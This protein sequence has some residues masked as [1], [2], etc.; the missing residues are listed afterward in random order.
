VSDHY[1]ILHEWMYRNWIATDIINPL[2]GA[3]VVR[4]FDSL[5]D[6]CGKVDGGCQSSLGFWDMEANFPVWT[7]ARI[8]GMAGSQLLEY[9]ICLCLSSVFAR[10]NKS[11]GTFIF[12]VHQ[13]GLVYFE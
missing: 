3:T 7:S 6:L 11:L 4:M 1:F 2:P 5:P 12:E 8:Q 10:C 13:V 9:R